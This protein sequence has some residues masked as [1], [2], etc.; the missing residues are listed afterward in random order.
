MAIEPVTH[1][2]K[3]I[4]GTVEP[5]THLEKVIEQY[6][7]GGGG[8]GMTEEFKQ[9]LLDAFN[10]VYWD[11]DKGPE[12]I[13]L[14]YNE[15]YPLSYITAV[16]TQSGTVYDTDSLDALKADLV[17]MAHYQDGTSEAVTD[18]ALSGTLSAGTSVITAEYR[19]K[20][21]TF[22]VTVTQLKAYQDGTTLYIL[23]G[24]NASQDGSTLSVS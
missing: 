18:Y 22:T 6:G 15:L 1:L 23:G 10:H 24:L 17:V 3:T 11:D 12:R 4:A 9:A 14:L 5:V 8:S 16:Y 21:A 20:S 19:G 13:Q 2:E 7:G